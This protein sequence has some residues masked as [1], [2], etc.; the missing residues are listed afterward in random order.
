MSGFESKSPFRN[1]RKISIV[2]GIL[3]LDTKNH[4]EKGSN[5]NATMSNPHLPRVLNHS[6]LRVCHLL[7]VLAEFT[8]F[9]AVGLQMNVSDVQGAISPTLDQLDE[10]NFQSCLQIL[11]EVG[12]TGGTQPGLGLVSSEIYIVANPG[13]Y[14]FSYSLGSNESD[15]L[16]DVRIMHP[17][18]PRENVSTTLAG[19]DATN[20]EKALY[21]E[22]FSNASQLAA[23]TCCGGSLFGFALPF[24]QTNSNADG[25]VDL[26]QSLR[27]Y[28]A[29]A[30][31]LNQ[32][33]GLW[34][35]ACPY[36]SIPPEPRMNTN[37]ASNGSDARVPLLLLKI[38]CLLILLA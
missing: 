13:P 1:T 25:S 8:A 18:L 11:A 23:E 21:A 26:T 4:T 35:T 17:F 19:I 29:V 12:L 27:Y 30:G 2:V 5:P 38:L 32:T 10:S 20:A 33:E 15:Y 28:V 7:L 34:Y 22:G 36:T 31:T 9:F 3:R 6:A 16:D 14:P 24:S 37:L